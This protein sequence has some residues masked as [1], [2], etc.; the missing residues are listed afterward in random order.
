M[1]LKLVDKNGSLGA[2]VFGFEF[3]GGR[4][5]L[6]ASKNVVDQ[7]WAEAREVIRACRSKPTNQNPKIRGERHCGPAAA[8]TASPS[9]E[10]KTESRRV[11]PAFKTAMN[12]R[13]V[14]RPHNL[15][16]TRLGIDCLCEYLAQK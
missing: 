5:G 6:G 15:C 4:Q 7:G 14:F 11:K 3:V 13:H 16:D 2:T 1:G 10:S 9:S 8:L 12:W